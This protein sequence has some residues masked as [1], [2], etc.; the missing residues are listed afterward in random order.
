VLSSGGRALPPAL[1][2]VAM[3]P[4]GRADACPSRAVLLM[5]EPGRAVTPNGIAHTIA[6]RTRWLVIGLFEYEFDRL[7]MNS[8]V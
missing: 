4:G 2:D 1:N 3:G 6:C 7:N 8:T 5:L